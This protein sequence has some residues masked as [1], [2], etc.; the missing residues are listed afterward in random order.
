IYRIVSGLKGTFERQNDVFDLE[1]F[2]VYPEVRQDKFQ[3]HLKFTSKQPENIR[4][5]QSYHI[6]LQL[7][8]TQEATLIARGGFFQSTGGQ[9]VYVLSPDGDFAI[10]RSIRIGRQN[11][12]Y[13]EIIVGLEPGEQVVTSSYDVFGDN[14]RL[15]FR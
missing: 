14:E 7:G 3:V 12:Q 11:P 15:V 1:L 10:R 2:K 4:A 6:S 9:W 5:G 13:Y 8:E